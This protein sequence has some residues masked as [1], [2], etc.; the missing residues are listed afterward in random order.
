MS[1]KEN[2]HYQ[3]IKEIN[4]KLS[5]KSLNKKALVI[6]LFAIIIILLIILIS[7]NNK[8]IKLNIYEKTQLIYNNENITDKL[9]DEIIIKDGATFISLNDVKEFLDNTIYQEDETKTIIT[10]SSKKLATLK[11]G[12]NN[13]TINGS[14]KQIEVVP[15]E[16][17]N[18]IYIPISEMQNIYNY[19]FKNIF[20][21]NVITI[22]S[23][24]KKQVKAYAK[25]NIVIKQDTKKT[26]KSIEKV[27]KGDELILIEDNKLAKVRTQNGNI[28][29]INKNKLTNIETKREDFIEETKQVEEDKYKEYDITKK[30][31]STYEN[32]KK[33][34]DFI[35]QDSIKN[36]NMYVKIAYKNEVN[37]DYERFKIE[38]IP[39]LQECGITTK[40]E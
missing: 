7:N 39:I 30:D 21:T 13:I 16:N 1:K 12:E 24:N 9:K 26:S 35:L 33:V 3:I 31:I 27:K 15:F 22:D 37:K 8:R 32:R 11:V 14:N 29:Y 10:T 5:N 2:K 17:N 34:I 18:I 20:E 36:D 38:V 4:A 6:M 19:E 40:I 23:L 25:K 28:G